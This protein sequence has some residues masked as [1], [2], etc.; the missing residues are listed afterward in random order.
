VQTHEQTNLVKYMFW[1]PPGAARGGWMTNCWRAEWRTKRTTS[2]FGQNGRR[3]AGV[4]TKLAQ[5]NARAI[6]APVS[7]QRG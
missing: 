2:A 5:Y 1:Y 7:R 6:E 3:S 4:F